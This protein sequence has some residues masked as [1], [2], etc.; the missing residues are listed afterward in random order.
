MSYGD[1]Q[2]MFRQSKERDPIKLLSNV[3][4]HVLRQG[5]RA[6]SSLIFGGF[7]RATRRE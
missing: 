7:R 1:G 5:E 4:A 6:G 2:G 3:Y